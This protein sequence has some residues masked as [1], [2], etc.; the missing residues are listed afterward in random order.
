MENT[1]IGQIPTQSLLG[2][3]PS[4]ILL[5]LYVSLWII[6]VLIVFLLIRE[7]VLWYWR[8]ND[9]TQSLQRIADSLE[10]IEENITFLTIKAG[11]IP[12]AE[13]QPKMDNNKENN[14]SDNKNEVKKNG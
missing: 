10:Q 7:L 1:I 12:E 3:M 2:Q 14:D 5:I 13:N 6:G 4:S 9:N 8:I 11:R